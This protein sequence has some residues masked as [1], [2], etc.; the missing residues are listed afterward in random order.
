MLAVAGLG[1]G[2]Y[3]SGVLAQ[4]AGAE[5]D[6]DI[7]AS[8]FAEDWGAGDLDALADW[9][10]PEKRS[11]FRATLDR[12]RANRGWSGP[13]PEVIT[14][15]SRVMQGTQDEPELGISLFVWGADNDSC[16]VDWQ[17]EPSRTRWYAY[18]LR[19]PPPPLQPA[20]EAFRVAWG[21]SEPN[22]LAP[23]FRPEAEDKMAA[24]VV[25]AAEKRGWSSHPR[26]E[27][28]VIQAEA[29]RDPEVQAWL[30]ARP[31]ARYPLSD[32]SGELLV[33]WDFHDASDAWLVT[34]FRFP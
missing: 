33:T 32:G 18:A 6:L 4:V 10:H 24:L 7:V 23:F 30:G 11:E 21:A 19:L 12:I 22:A 14:N 20:A 2:L 3:G 17:F 28:P 15:A 8:R 29:A 34:G 26:L 5:E 27:A 13:F 1:Y 31:E 16:H 25:R 9:F